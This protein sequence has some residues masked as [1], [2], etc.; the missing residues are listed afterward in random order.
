MT[1][2]PSCS[3]TSSM[4]TAIPLA[5]VRALLRLA[6]EQS[7][8][9]PAALRL[10]R[11]AEGISEQGKQGL[12][13][14]EKHLDGLCYG[15]HPWRLLTQYLFGRSRYLAHLLA[16]AEFGARAGGFGGSD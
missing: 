10:A 5:D 4:A 15:T 16:A 11:E 7:R 9:F 3:S 8:P 12:R 6:S 1:S 2:P 13:R 14:L